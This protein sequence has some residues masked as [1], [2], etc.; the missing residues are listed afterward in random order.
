MAQILSFM[1]DWALFLTIFLICLILYFTLVRDEETK[2]RVKRFLFDYG[3][4]IVALIVLI[5]GWNRW[6]TVAES[7]IGEMRYAL[8]IVLL[9]G[10]LYLLATNFLYRERY[11][12]IFF[13]ADGVSGSCNLYYDAGDYTI[14][15]LGTSGKSDFAGFVFPWYFPQRIVVIP[16]DSWQF[17]GNNIV[18]FIKVK[19]QDP[20]HDVPEAALEI[21]ERDGRTTFARDEIY[22][23]ILSEETILRE[24]DQ[25]ELIKKIE[26]LEARNNELSSMLDAKM[27]KVSGFVSGTE[28]IKRSLKGQT[29]RRNQTSQEGEGDKY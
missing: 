25:A 28:A 5:Y 19:R 29:W 13:Q 17:N 6:G 12:S 16:R 7:D 24:P 21:I 10:D 15:Y 4:W 27:K 23:G 2:T 9:A 26:D 11:H 22:F 14:F 18:T 8:F 20:I 3:I 1:P